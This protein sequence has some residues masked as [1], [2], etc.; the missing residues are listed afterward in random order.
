MRLVHIIR[1]WLTHLRLGLTR[2]D[3]QLHDDRVRLWDEF[4]RAWMTVLQRQ[5]DLTQDMVQT[6]R[7]V[8]ES[9]SVMSSQHLDMLGRELVR[10]CDNVEK[11]GLVDYQMGVAEEEIMDRECCTGSCVVRVGC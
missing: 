1:A 8:H 11:H 6:G 4:N 3:E 7:S 10:M 5:H 2:D 9:Q